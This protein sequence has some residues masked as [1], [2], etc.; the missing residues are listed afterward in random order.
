MKIFETDII[1]FEFSGRLAEIY[2]QSGLSF[3]FV[4][5][6]NKQCHPLVKCRD[7]LQDAIKAVLT[8]TPASIYSFEFSAKDNP[9]L[10]FTKTRLLVKSSLD[11]KKSDIIM[12]AA[13]KLLHHYENIMEVP[14]TAISKLKSWPSEYLIDGPDIWMRSPVLISVYT[15]LLRLGEYNL[16]FTLDD[17][18]SLTMAYQ[19][20]ISLGKSS[21]EVDYLK[22]VYKDLYNVLKFRNNIFTFVD[23]FDAAY[24]RQVTTRHFH[25]NSGIVALC[26]KS[27]SSDFLYHEEHLKLMEVE[28]NLKKETVQEIQKNVGMLSVP[29]M[30]GTIADRS[31]KYSPI[32]PFFALENDKNIVRDFES[33]IELLCSNYRRHCESYKIFRKFNLIVTFAGLLDN[34]IYTENHKKALFFA[35][36]V[37]NYFE[38]TAGMQKSKISTIQLKLPGNRKQCAWM[39]SG[40]E[41]WLKS[42]VMLSMYA[43]IVRISSSYY[44]LSE[45]AK[46]IKNIDSGVIRQIGLYKSPT[47][48]YADRQMSLFK[49]HT[50]KLHKILENRDKLFVEKTSISAAFFINK[51][52]GIGSVF[53]ESGIKSLIN[54]GHVDKK[55]LK[56]YKEIIK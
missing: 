13:I 16:N 56:K 10:D 46:K 51:T 9:M 50:S 35:K 44:R 37:I 52:P 34:P 20:L 53:S 54:G 36:K 23:N 26:R 33:C 4:S 7:F 3:A 42:P 47:A 1:P 43:H 45:D 24:Y 19:E 29:C 30:C 38:S 12:D 41:D 17:D 18:D 6:D 22:S 14:N 49:T 8:N 32:K 48:V 15:L 39:F 25:D 2:Q 11:Q 21:N 28:K 31:T 55:L 27:N 5:P 40:P